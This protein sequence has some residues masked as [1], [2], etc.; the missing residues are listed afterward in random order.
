MGGVVEAEAADGA[1]VVAR[2]GGEQ[3]SDVLGCFRQPLKR[4]LVLWL[5]G[6]MLR[7]RCMGKEE[8]GM[9]YSY[10]VGDPVGSEYVALDDARL[11]GSGDVGDAMWEDGIAIVGAPIAGK[12]SDKPLGKAKK[13]QLQPLALRSLQLGACLEAIP[14]MTSSSSYG[15]SPRWLESYTS[16]NG[17]DD[18]S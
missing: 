4:V 10:L 14:R 7:R 8:D 9:A 18:C 2:E 6:V 11:G 13:C 5:R 15:E 1:D 16:F 17:F 3:E 12:E